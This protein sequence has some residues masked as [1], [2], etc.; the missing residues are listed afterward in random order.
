[1]STGTE[2]LYVFE[3]YRQKYGELASGT[4]ELIKKYLDDGYTP[5]AAVDAA[6]AKNQVFAILQT[7]IVNAATQAAVLGAGMTALTDYMQ[8][9]MKKV[10]LNEVWASDKLSLSKRLYEKQPEVKQIV[11]DTISNALKQGTNWVETS[12]KLYDGYGHGGKIPQA[13][14][15]D[16]LQNLV[17]QSRKV[18]A[19]DI[20]AKKQYQ[21]LINAAQKQIDQLAQEGAPSRM[22]KA[23]FQK[24]LDS[25][26]SLN[27]K[28]LDK[29]IQVAIEEKTRYLAD[30][31]ARTEL[32]RAWGDG[33]FSRYNGNEAVVAYRWCL[34]TRHPFFDI[35][36]V[37][38]NVNAFGLGG[39]IYPKDTFPDYPA[40]PHCM[41]YI[42]PVYVNMVDTKK[43]TDFNP[44]AVQGYIS[45]LDKKDQQALLGVDGVKAGVENWQANL[46][47]WQGYENPQSRFNKSDLLEEEKGLGIINGDNSYIAEDKLVKYILNKEHDGPGKD[48]A[49]AFEKA[50]GYTVDDWKE[51]QKQITDN[52]VKNPAIAVGR[53]PIS[54]NLKYTVS[55]ELQGLNGKTASI[56]TVWEQEEDGQFRMV[57]AYVNKR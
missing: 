39:G 25:T 54:N 51:L 22:L 11:V 8:A 40:H 30:R 18:L 23:T 31:I 49:V 45:N 13:E 53:T 7:D 37:H 2:L 27:A 28:A 1:M 33:F 19:G 50:L 41:C 6:F 24:L 16:Y 20:P 57:T 36:D 38:A 10:L 42:E 5:Q 34:N 17:D 15:P 52:L 32:T 48:K 26:K 21:S 44:K 56:L 43:Q 29:A 12:R 55:M 3:L 4:T 14:L 35:C 46:R 47:Q 9:N